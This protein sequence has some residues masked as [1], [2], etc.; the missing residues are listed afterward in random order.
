MSNRNFELDAVEFDVDK[1]VRVARAVLEAA[2]GLG[3][4]DAASSHGL[5]RVL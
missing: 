5:V 2:H 1:I 3:R 4:F